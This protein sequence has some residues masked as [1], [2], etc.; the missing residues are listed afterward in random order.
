MNDNTT[1]IQQ[2]DVTGKD[3]EK[4]QEASGPKRH[5]IRPKWLRVTLKTLM[6][7]VIV[8]LMLPV[9][10]YLPPVQDLVIGIA[11]RE[12]NKSTGMEIGIGKFRL[13]FPLNVHLKDVYVLTAPNDTMVRAGE[14]IADVK[15]LPLFGLD[16]RLNKLDL[17]DGYYKMVSADSSM[18]LSINAGQLTVDDKSSVDIRKSRIHL[19]KVLLKNGSVG[20]YMNAWK[21]KPTPEDTTESTP[22]YIEA[23]DI[24]MENFGFGMSM[25]PTID[26]L[27]LKVKDVALA[28]GIIDLGKNEVK[29]KRA[30]MSGGTVRYV[31]PTPEWVKAHPAPPSEPS[32]GPPMRIM[33]DSISVDNLAAVYCTKGV[34]PMPG[35]DPSYIS[36]SDVGLGMRNFYNEASTVK[37]PIT[38]LQAKER[39]G[40]QIVRGNGT[41]GIDSIGLGLQE[42]ALQT[43]YST[44]NA[45]AEVPF[46]VMAM[47]PDAPMAVK[48]NG[49]LG[50]PDVEAFMPDVKAYLAKV[51]RRKPLDFNLNASGTLAR[52]NIPTLKAEMAGVLK[53]VASGFAHNVL[54][55][56]NLKA[57]L[58][59]DGAL[60]DPEL[61]NQ[62]LAES[63]MRVPAFHITGTADADRDQYGADLSIR[64]TAGDA[65]ARG[66]VT[67]NSENYNADVTTEGLNVAQFMPSLGIGKVSAHVKATGAGFNPLSGRSVTDAKVHVSS[68]EYNSRTYRDI[69][70]DA[71]LHGDGL[72]QV[73]ASS[74][75]PG[76]N[77]DFDVSGMIKPDDYQ[78]DLV[79]HINDLN[80]Q[81]LGFSD[82]LCQGNGT[83]YLSGTASPGK[84]LYDAD[85]KLVDFDWN[86]PNMFIHLPGGMHAVVKAD[87]A[88]TFVDI[89]SHL[90]EAKFSS[91]NGLQSLISSFQVTA[92]TMMRQ[93]K[94]RNI[95]VEAISRQMPQFSLDVNA[96]GRGLLGQFLAPSG[97]AIDTVWGHIGRDSIINGNVRLLSLKTGA[98]NADTI[99]LTLKERGELLDYKIHMGNRPGTF[100]EFAKVNVNGYLGH[101]RLGAFLT[102]YNIR[103]EM[104]YRLGLTASLNDSIVS[105][106]FTP[107]K[108]TIA[109]MPWT[110]NNDNYLDYNIRNMHVDAN[111][112]AMSKESSI[113]ARTEPDKDGNERLR[114]K[115][116]NLHI[117]D[118][119]GMSVTA[120][121]VKGAISTDLTVNYIDQELRGGGF[122]QVKDL[123]YD[124]TRVGDF[125]L[126][127]DGSYA[128]NTGKANA[129][130]SLYVNGSKAITAYARMGTSGEVTPDSIGVR[131]TR[132][133]LSVANAF[134]GNT[135][136]LNGFLNG[137]MRMD[138]TFAEPRFNGGI[139]MDSAS[140]RI[141]MAAATLRMDT[142]RITVK[143]NL[144]DLNQF[145]IYAANKN[146]LTL[147]GT[148][149]AG[150]FNNILF[151]LK[152]NAQNM[153]LINTDKRSK[154]DLYGKIFLNLG[155]TVHGPMNRMDVRANLNV[156]GNTDAT[157]RLN[158]PDAQLT[159]QTENDVVKFVNFNDTTQVQKSDTVV[160]S[161]LNMRINAN[162]TISP[163]TRLEVLLSTNGTDK[164]QIQPTANL[165]YYQSY[166]GDMSMTGTLTLGTGFARYAIPV[167]GEKMFDFDP[168][169]TITWTGNVANPTLNVTATDMMKASVTQDGNSRLVNFLVTLRATNPV[170]QLKVAFD[171]STNDDLAIQ[172]ELQS[173][174]AD[175]RQTQAMNLLLY[176][177]YSGQGGTKANVNSSNMLYSFLESQLNSLAAKYVRGVDLSFGI[178]QYEKANN[179]AR[180]TETSYSY[181]VS[182]SLFNNRFKIRVGG[183][184]S[185][186]QN[187]EENL[188]QNLVSDI[189]FEYM[190]K[191]TQSMNMS[192]Q[193]FRHQGYESIL[194]GEITETGV[195]FEL[196][197]KLANLFHLFRFRRG[198]RASTGKVVKDSTAESHGVPTQNALTT[199][200]T[201]RM[202]STSQPQDSTS[203]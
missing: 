54:E 102:Q 115:I 160:E 73:V 188:A 150:K 55:P 110:L 112:Q 37:L 128:L 38:R 42:V 139:S 116:E 71:L 202:D 85:L 140:V 66:H 15:L 104:G 51:L 16:V 175:Q 74:V 130:A 131:L 11:C 166:M 95:S 192:V 147:D 121:P 41:I 63:E 179:G 126:D 60:M 35:F 144:L 120:P 133:P 200:A 53:L 124:K 10:L 98:V 107:L 186:D 19:N 1:N 136:Q 43:I 45:T 189:S 24:R 113:L 197:R 100:D 33:G 149:D 47:E 154:G 177:Q 97:I 57:H 123:R 89:D 30:S 61:A 194:E 195:A 127:V 79:A 81:Q 88:S 86:L 158:I 84:W 87:I 159:T 31:Q 193:L 25:L 142:S 167:V 163:G 201:T 64:S 114:L 157:Y 59:I 93:I 183:N 146:P 199:P 141:P 29:W 190:I 17:I 72:L 165:N 44:I 173:M 27:D 82:S 178:N 34:K 132:F 50:L 83:I 111:L 151:D 184:Y 99:G 156:L 119:L 7:I 145:D 182:K 8:I 103:K 18:M 70:A 155:A 78:V 196:K 135:V 203:R 20:L 138:G 13:S 134:L 181:Q 90:T 5:R 23:N 96:S 117:E 198:K 65:A 76:L 143:D 2:D 105:V 77:L 169:S 58:D 164:V 129:D 152:A 21:K 101:N 161:S 176:G 46:A 4:A 22:F 49:S 6:W 52:L 94:A 168:A 36:V 187:P 108:S 109:Y 75:N 106:H 172:N 122:L 185:T 137:D 68:I 62:F 174:S 56:K 9:L 91:P 26:T 180:S 92:D 14:A 28:R 153:Q 69:K 191:Q 118:F 32:S 148:V 40:L 12:V 170:D 171:L 67:L 162:V 48:A 39:S 80:L 125:D 3:A